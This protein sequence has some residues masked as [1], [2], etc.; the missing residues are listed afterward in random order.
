[1]TA[2][3]LRIN[4][5]RLLARLQALGAVGALPGGGVARLALTD[6]D[7]QGRAL[8]SGWMR[9]L[10][11][12]VTTDAIGNIFGLRAGRLDGPPVMTGS[13]IDTVRTGGLYD[14]NYGVLAGLEVIETLND[15]G[16]VTDH[17]LCVA[18]FTNE[19]GAR[20]TP[21]MMG[22]LVYVGGLPLDD[23][24]NAVGIDGQRLGDCLQAIGAAG[25][26]PVGSPAVRAYIE[27]HIEQGPV[28]E[29][30]GITIG[31]VEQVQGI[32]WT[33]VTVTGTSNHA[34]TTPMR[35]RHD[36]GYVAM[37]TAAFVRDLATR[38]GGDQV[39]TVGAIDLKPNL[40]NV[41]ANHAR[42]TIDLRNTD[43]G[44]LQQAEAETAS[45]LDTLAAEEGV[46]VTR[47]SLARFE[48]VA[49]DPAMVDRVEATARAQG[50]S[51]RRM[52]SGAGH[53]AQMLARVCPTGMIFVPSAQGISH[54]IHEHTNPADLTAGA[55][56][57]LQ[58]LLDLAHTTTSED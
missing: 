5:P 12:A 39:A 22:S 47:R 8:V 37:A 58:V 24:L 36:A 21:D 25:T 7:R 6:E 14:G 15:A 43:E 46:T 11:L 40:I 41:V 2:T 34:G 38:M 35:L 26:V 4:G 52:P 23:A 19:E 1:M 27:L 57:L 28:L 10:G 9:D 50:Q 29:E 33:E 42:F 16:I 53:D 44:L 45:F 54:N 49:F 32:S 56:V 13:H 17:P 48:P 31:A 18:V 51:V 30:E 55:N 20:F 3:A